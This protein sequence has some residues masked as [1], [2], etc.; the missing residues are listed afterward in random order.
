MKR[1]KN[2]GGLVIS[3]VEKEMYSKTLENLRWKEDMDIINHF[4]DH[5]WLKPLFVDG[6]RVGITDC[7]FVSNPCPR[8]KNMKPTYDKG[9]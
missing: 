1:N 7:C 2:Y 8:H 5:V 3:L 9:N 6:K 4:G